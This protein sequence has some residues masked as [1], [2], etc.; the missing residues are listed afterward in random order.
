M[1]NINES[2][3]RR[4]I[5]NILLNEIKQFNLIDIMT[6]AKAVLKNGYGDGAYIF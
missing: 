4:F 1:N 5:Q 6:A 2:Q 3:I